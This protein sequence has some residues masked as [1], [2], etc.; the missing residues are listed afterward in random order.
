MNKNNNE[1]IN[2]SIHGVLLLNK[3]KTYGINKKNGK[4][5]YKFMPYNNKYPTF[6]VE[7]KIKKVSFIKVNDN[8]Y[9]IIIF[10]KWDDKHPEGTLQKIF[11][12][13]SYLETYYEYILSYNN[14]LVS[15]RDLT[16]III[17]NIN[18]INYNK[19]NT[20]KYNNDSSHND[21]YPFEDHTINNKTN[22]YTIDPTNCSDYDD[23]YSIVQKNN[24]ITLNIYISNVPFIIDKLNIWELIQEKISTI[25]LPNKKHPL[26]PS[27]LTD[28]VCSLSKGKI[29]HAFTLNILLETTGDVFNTD[30][31]NNTPCIKI[32]KTW[33]S[34]CKINVK[35]NYV[36]EEPS[37]LESQNYNLLRCTL[38]QLQKNH[39]S[40]NINYIDDPIMN[41]HDVIQYMMIMM[42]SM[43][44]EILLMNRTGIFRSDDLTNDNDKVNDKVKLYNF[45]NKNREVIGVY[46][47]IR[48]K[49]TLINKNN[50]T[51]DNSYLYHSYLKQTAYVHI[52]SPIRRII[53]LINMSLIQKSLGLYKFKESSNN[54]INYW[55]NNVDNINNTSRIIS[56]LQNEFNNLNLCLTNNNNIMNIIHICFVIDIKFSQDITTTNCPLEI[57]PV[58]YTIYIPTQK[59]FVRLETIVKLEL[60]SKNKCKLFLFNDNKQTTQC[61]KAQLI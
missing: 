16:K 47:N 8:K 18:N 21:Y 24:Y 11:N 44:G 54:F 35:K 22:I 2:T 12:E 49:Y 28:N 41:S 32:K 13:G 42:N 57:I 25:Y 5:L 6:L 1:L 39:Q 9:G 34:N 61:I 46:D 60:Y 26:L 20:I 52:T 59:L 14:L 55:Y 38:I 3:N 31:T 58:K 17:K 51:E 45:Q 36:Y 40:M 43:C 56:K 33:F 23:A 15:Q 27:I 53:D 50:H 19:N 10:K 37:L 29:S 30:F 4:F 48:T 7:Y